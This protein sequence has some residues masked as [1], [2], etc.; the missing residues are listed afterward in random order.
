MVWDS[1]T[2]WRKGR[3]FT[4]TC[5]LHTCTASPIISIPHQSGTCVTT[6]E[7]TSIHH[8][9]PK[10]I[11]HS[12]AHCLCWTFYG[13]GQIP[14]IVSLR[15]YSLHKK[16][17]FSVYSS[18]RTPLPLLVNTDLLTI[19]IIWLFP[20]GHIVGIIYYVASFDWLL[21]LSN[22]HL[23]FFHVVWWTFWYVC[24]CILLF[25]FSS[26]S[27]LFPCLFCS[28]DSTYEWNH[29]VFVFIW[30]ISLANIWCRA[31]F[32]MLISH[33]FIFSGDASV[34]VFGPFLNQ[35]A[36]FLTVEF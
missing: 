9:Q 16:I 34:K 8:N 35:V 33:L 6:D 23:I 26:V 17:L 30:V 5:H 21:S 32:H 31:S 12:R 15:V 14:N 19:F 2:D 1:Q 3:D 4:H 18:L 27:I 36:C 29:L 10:S 24:S 20:K 13:F 7:P 11:V 28:L 25:I 22:M